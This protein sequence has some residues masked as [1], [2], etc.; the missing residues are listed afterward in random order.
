MWFRTEDLDADI[1]VIQSKG[2]K[3]HF[4]SDFHNGK[5]LLK[6]CFRKL[7]KDKEYTAKDINSKQ[8]LDVIMQNANLCKECKKDMEDTLR[9]FRYGFEQPKKTEV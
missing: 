7:N 8:E 1:Q 6:N 5:G 2:G 9:L 3:I 4:A